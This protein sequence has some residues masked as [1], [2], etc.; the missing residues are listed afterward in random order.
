MGTKFFFITFLFL[1]GCETLDYGESFKSIEA[2]LGKNWQ[3]HATPSTNNMAGVVISESKDGSRY[4]A[5]NYKGISEAV[6]EIR[7]GAGKFSNGVTLGGV[8]NFLGDSGILGKKQTISGDLINSKTNFI[9]EYGNTRHH[10]IPDKKVKHI[11]SAVSQ[12]RLDSENIYTLYRE[13]I[14][15]TDIEILMSRD[16]FSKLS[17]DID[18]GVFTAKP[19][20]SIYDNNS[21][22]ISTKKDARLG[23]CTLSYPLNIL[24]YAADGGTIVE[25]G[26]TPIKI[27]KNS[28]IE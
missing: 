8:S 26:S 15:A 16:V 7:V 11:V 21:Y 20:F 28:I 25:I 10:T 22:K 4:V 9:I 23:V 1:T 19:N 3:C 24:G 18:I 12:N 2:A 17:G 13:S 27:D 5:G 14:S 6:D